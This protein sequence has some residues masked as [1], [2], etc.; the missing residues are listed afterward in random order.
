MAV[1]PRDPRLKKPTGRMRH[2]Q[3]EKPHEEGAKGEE[4]EKDDEAYLLSARYA[5]ND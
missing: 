2:K 3:A 1:V 4:E 5:R